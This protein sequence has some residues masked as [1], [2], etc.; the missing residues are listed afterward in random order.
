[1]FYNH[2]QGH[3]NA[4]CHTVVI[5][6]TSLSVINLYSQY[7]MKFQFF[8]YI[9]DTCIHGFDVALRKSISIKVAISGQEIFTTVHV[10]V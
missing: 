7:L 1:M 9:Y 10:Y 4:W 6:K 8:V 3:M 5:K 2:L